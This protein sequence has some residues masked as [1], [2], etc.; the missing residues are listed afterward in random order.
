MEEKEQ[1]Y[2]LSIETVSNFIIHNYYNKLA[3]YVKVFFVL[4]MIRSLLCF[5]K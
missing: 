4:H 2:S 1:M 5:F 3:M